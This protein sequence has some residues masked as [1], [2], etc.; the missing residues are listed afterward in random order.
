MTEQ[1][2]STPAR[3]GQYSSKHRFKLIAKAKERMPDVFTHRVLAAAF[4]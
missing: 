3:C 4:L 1:K 2:L